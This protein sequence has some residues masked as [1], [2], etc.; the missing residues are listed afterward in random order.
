MALPWVKVHNIQNWVRATK[1]FFTALYTLNLNLWFVLKRR[2]MTHYKS[3]YNSIHILAFAIIWLSIP[4]NLIM[5]MHVMTIRLELREIRPWH[6]LTT[7]WH[8]SSS[9]SH[10]GTNI[11]GIAT[12]V[13]NSKQHRHFSHNDFSLSVRITFQHSLSQ[14]IHNP[15]IHISISLPLFSLL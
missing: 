9:I 13:F 4:I 12:N 1:M 10:R 5:F 15:F 11:S 3:L 7:H 2:T 14:K 6:R 8:L